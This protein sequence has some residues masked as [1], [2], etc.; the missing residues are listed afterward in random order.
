MGLQKLDMDQAK[1]SK[2]LNSD[3][4]GSNTSDTV[5][6][7]WIDLGGNEAMSA[8]FC[9]AA[10]VVNN[11]SVDITVQDSDDS[12][13]SHSDA[14]D[15]DDQYLTRTESDLTL[16]AADEVVT[17]GYT[18]PKRYVRVQIDETSW[19][20][21]TFGVLSWLSSHDRPADNTTS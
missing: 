2:C 15:V 16:D 3:K 6:G 5:D 11:G 4:T 21:H 8:T 12:S 9:I 17:I 1:V 20:G 14:A 7:D 18:G 10:V 13:G 19:D